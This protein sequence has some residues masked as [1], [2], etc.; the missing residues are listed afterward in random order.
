MAIGNYSTLE[1][2]ENALANRRKNLIELFNRVQKGTQGFP[3][4]LQMLGFPRLIIKNEDEL[5]G[6]IKEI[7]ESLLL[8]KPFITKTFV[9]NSIPDSPEEEGITTITEEI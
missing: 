7:S 9:H 5:I 8:K 4:N 6:R 3:V 1:A 2:Y